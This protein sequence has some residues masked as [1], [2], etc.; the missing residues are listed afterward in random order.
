[1]P[2]ISLSTDIMVGFPG[3]TEADLEETLDLMNRVRFSYAYMYHYNP[4]E[5]TAA[6]ELPGRIDYGTK[7]ERLSRVIALQKAHR[8]ELL[9]S[10]IGRREQVL[11]EGISRKNADEYSTRT[12]RDDTAVVTGNV[13]PGSFVWARLRSLKGTTFRADLEA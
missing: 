10:R 1:M 4:R 6:T 9:K 5:G 13:E 2:D 12:E 7:I 8:I 3:E 11:V